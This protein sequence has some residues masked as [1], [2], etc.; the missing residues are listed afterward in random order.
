MVVVV[1]VSVVVVVGVFYMVVVVGVSVWLLGM[2]LLLLGFLRVVSVV[3]IYGTFASLRA[4][5]YESVSQHMKH[6]RVLSQQ[7]LRHRHMSDI[8][9]CLT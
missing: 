9:T 5:M 6:L 1:G 4:C 2:W 8:D 3:R 7:M